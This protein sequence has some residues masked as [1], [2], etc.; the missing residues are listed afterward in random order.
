MRRGWDFDRY[1]GSEIAE[2]FGSSWAFMVSVSAG[3]V[4]LLVGRWQLSFTRKAY[5]PGGGR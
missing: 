2:S 3:G 5:R 1:A 4:D